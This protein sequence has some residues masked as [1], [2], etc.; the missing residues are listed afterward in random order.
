[1][2][3]CEFEVY[4]LG[5]GFKVRRQKTDRWGMSAPV[6]AV[7]QQIQAQIYELFFKEIGEGLFV[8]DL[9][10]QVIKVANPA[11]EYFTGLEPA[12]YQNAKID[13]IT[14]MPVPSELKRERLISAELLETPG[15]HSDILVAHRLGA[16]KFVT[17]KV[18]HTKLNDNTNYAFVLLSDDTERQFLLRDLMAKHQTLESSHTELEQ[19]HTQLRI[20]GEKIM[21]ASKMAALGEL[22]TG[23]SHELNQPL[24][25]IR[26]FAQEIGDILKTEARPKKSLIRKLSN[27]VIQSADKMAQLLAHFRTFARGGIKSQGLG[28]ADSDAIMKTEKFNAADLVLKTLRLFSHQFEKRKITVEV[29]QQ[30]PIML[31]QLAQPLEQIIINLVSN[32][33]DACSQSS[34]RPS[35]ILISIRISPVNLNSVEFRVTDNGTGISDADRDKIFD[36]FFTT[37]D[38]GKGTGL[39]LS[40][41]YSIAEKLG[42]TLELEHSQLGRGTT[43]LCSIPMIFKNSESRLSAGFSES[44]VSF[45]GQKKGAA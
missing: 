43:F 11:F 16:A 35:K 42:G 8:F 12:Q 31:D 3:L 44:L 13:V 23:L 4:L 1:L 19:A 26:G 15:I 14:Q 38:I 2:A 25:G 5:G 36:P 30:Q 6:L 39:G 22:A 17:A 7:S 20:S 28:G 27:E 10:E 9:K 29:H 18:I 45:Q 24:T 34:N 33:R 37:K 32:A 41:S 21:H 40:I